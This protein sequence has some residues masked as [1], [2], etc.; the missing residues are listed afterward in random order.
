MGVGVLQ[1]FPCHSRRRSKQSEA[2]VRAEGEEAAAVR[3][4]SVKASAVETKPLRKQTVSP[5]PSVASA[6][7]EEPPVPVA[8]SGYAARKARM[9]F[10]HE[11]DAHESGVF[12]TM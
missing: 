8:A 1:C 2:K 5:S 7:A 10:R 4:N 9:S 6:Q 3:E 12:S 11:M